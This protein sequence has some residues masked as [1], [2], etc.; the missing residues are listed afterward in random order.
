[1][2]KPMTETNKYQA[3]FLEKF[4]ANFNAKYPERYAKGIEK[5]K[6][7]IHLDYTIDQHLEN[8]EEEMLDGLAY[9]FAIKLMVKDM[10]DYC[11]EQ[12]GM[13][14]CKNCGLGQ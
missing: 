1:M 11:Q 6:T 8:A 13:R 10:L 3:E 2:A 4:M 9:I 12:N 7:V 5:Y 14:V